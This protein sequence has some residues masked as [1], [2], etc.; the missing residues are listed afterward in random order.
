MNP[1]RRFIAYRLWSIA[2]WIYPYSKHEP[3]EKDR[4]YWSVNTT[5]EATEAQAEEV[6]ERISEF[7]CG[8]PSHHPLDPCNF[9]VGGMR[10]LEDEE[11]AE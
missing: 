1:I 3:D 5:F 7:A 10:P 2:G 8:R 4:R 11:D 9:R 6:W